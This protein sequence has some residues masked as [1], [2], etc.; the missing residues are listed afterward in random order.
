MNHRLIVLLLSVGFGLC[1]TAETAS[2]QSAGDQQ[3]AETDRAISGQ[4]TSQRVTFQWP[5]GEIV[6]Q[7]AAPDAGLDYPPDLMADIPWDAPYR[8]VADVM[9]AFNDSRATEN[10]QL[11][12][13]LKSMAFPS[14]SAWDGMND[15]QKALWLINEERTARGLAPLDNLEKN[16]QEVAQAYAQWL[17]DNNAWGHE[18]NGKTPWERL[19]AKAPIAACHDFL[20]VAENLWVKGTT[21]TDGI[22]LVI[23]QAIY[24]WMY[25]DREQGWG[26]RHAIL[27]TPYND[28]SGS[29]GKE[30]FL[31]IGHAQGKYTVKG[32]LLANTDMVVMN[33]FDPCATWQY[34]APPTI[35]PPPAPE[36]V[37]PPKAVPG[38]FTVSG[39]LPAPSG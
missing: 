34:A 12:I 1:L 38:T 2:V 14:Q 31:G 30:G 13:Y 28:N 6:E 24:D 29:A 5:A 22:P 17:L 16:V 32:L 39:R 27:W 25:V 7:A 4:Y 36:P 18:A 15:G 26:H 3:A 10:G 11:H 21:S 9:Q 8:N 35:E 20:G 37:V 23:E 19:D 33:V